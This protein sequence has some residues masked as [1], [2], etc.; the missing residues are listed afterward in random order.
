MVTETGLS[1]KRAVPFLLAGVLVFVVYLY[2][3]VGINEF[4][5]ILST[6][7]LFFYGL[8]V[9]VLFLTM[10]VGALAWHYLLRP[11]GVRVSVR[12]TFLFSWIGVFVD[13]LVPAESIGGDAARVYLMSKES[14]ES[15]GKVV[16]SVVSQRI[17]AMVMSLGSL[18]FTSVVLYTIKYDLHPDVLNLVLLITVV[19][20]FSLCFMVL[21]VVK[22]SLTERVV[23]AVLRF[24]AFVSRGRLSLEGMR[25]KVFELLGSFYGSIGG[26]LRNPRAL[27]LPVFFSVVSW[28][29]SIFV[30]CLVFAALG[31]QVD[32]VLIT[33]VYSVSV[34][35]QSI[36]LGVGG[37][38]AVEVV[39]SS[40]YGLL[41]FDTVVA[42]AATV[43]I[44]ILWV[45]LRIVVGFVAVQWI[46]L[47]D[48][49][50]NLQQDLF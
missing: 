41:G 47:K 6:V 17:L 7:D 20:T 13:L 49:T 9:G 27:V 38:G 33:V 36:P 11:L 32:F 23:D 3:F 16:A 21:C 31:Q 29:F 46:D 5:D 39:M 42:A 28:I 44:R 4:F 14:G 35:I 24:L 8:A 40:L 10:F 34:N 43:L 19:T 45:W 22:R 30:S 15:A 1:L 37:L 18:I 26:L 12:K 48:L 2:F 50:K 25:G